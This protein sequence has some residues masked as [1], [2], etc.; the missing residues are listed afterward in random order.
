MTEY[1]DEVTL[2]VNVGD[3]IE[4]KSATRSHC[5]KAIRKVTA[6]QD[7]RVTVTKY[8]TWTNFA[9]RENEIIR[10]VTK[11]EPAPAPDP[12]KCVRC[13]DVSD[14]GPNCETCGEPLLTAEDLENWAV[15]LEDKKNRRQGAVA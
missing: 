4:F 14:E 9:V 11:A 5:R 8:H 3:E 2:E 1:E 7:G 6:C 15:E 10:V 12:M 13:Q